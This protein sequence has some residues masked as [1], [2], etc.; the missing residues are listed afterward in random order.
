MDGGSGHAR[1]LNGVSKCFSLHSRSR[2]AFDFDIVAACCT[3]VFFD[4]RENGQGLLR[5]RTQ[6]S[7]PE[8]LAELRKRA[9]DYVVVDEV[10]YARSPRDE[11]DFAELR[12]VCAECVCDP[13]GQFA[14]AGLAHNRRE[15]GA[16]L[17]AR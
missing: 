15:V 9:F 10:H 2:L 11:R 7:R 12:H 8:N 6:L 16:V 14:I 4:V 5:N 1:A 13:L 3:F 17:H